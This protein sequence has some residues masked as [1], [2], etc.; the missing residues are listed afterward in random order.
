[1]FAEIITTGSEFLLGESVDTNS[2]YIAR[3]LRDAGIEVQ[4]LITVGDDLER[5]TAVLREALQRSQL[6]IT[7][8]GLGPTVDDVTREA[9]ARAVGQ[10][11]VFREDLLEDIA[12]FFARAGR[13]MSENNRRQAYIPAGATPIRNPVGTAPA[14]IVETPSSTIICLPGVPREMEYLMQ[15]AVLPYLRRRW[16][17]QQSMV[18][19]TLHTCSVGESTIDSLIG[20]LESLNNPS[21]GLVA[22]AGRTDIRITARAVTPA[23]ARRMVDEVEEEI[24]RRLGDI[25]FG[26]DEETLEG[27]VARELAARRYSLAVLETNTAGAIADRFRRALAELGQERL[28]LVSRVEPVIPADTPAASLIPRA[29]D[30]AGNTHTDIVMCVF[31]SGEPGQ[32][33]HGREPGRTYIVLRTSDQQAVL[34]FRYGG[35]DPHT[36]GWITTRALDCLRRVLL[37][38]P[39]KEL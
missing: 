38:L 11:L 12:A 10:E 6:I 20:D 23:E 14:F 28:L 1:M 29:D 22:H 27:I 15:N 18:T 8:G 16:G 4:Y 31:G 32:G 5:M 34:P 21:V 33:I 36:Q 17:A 35:M 9:V 39:L 25:I 3:C 26:V 19:R 37:G 24:R 2:A 7:T 30:F 13:A